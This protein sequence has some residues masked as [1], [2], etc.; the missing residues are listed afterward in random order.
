[1]IKRK[2]VPILIIVFVVLIGVACFQYSAN[3]I[4]TNKRSTGLC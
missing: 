3:M 2:I 4:I 1:M